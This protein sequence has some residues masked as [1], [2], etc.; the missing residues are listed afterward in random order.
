MKYLVRGFV[1]LSVFTLAFYFSGCENQSPISSL[2]QELDSKI[3]DLIVQSNVGPIQIVQVDPEYLSSKSLNKKIESDTI[4]YIEEFMEADDDGE[5]EIKGGQYG[6]SKLK[7]D[8]HSL[9]MDM[10]VYMEWPNNSTFEGAIGSI[11]Y[12][13]NVVLNKPAELELTIKRANL[14]GVSESNLALFMYD[15][16]TDQWDN[17][18]AEFDDHKIKVD[19]DRFGKLKVFEVV[20]GE[21]RELY[22]LDA[23]AHF[24]KKL[25]K[26]DKGGKVEVGDKNSG[27]SKLDFDKYSLPHDVTI[28]FEWAPANSVIGMLNNMEFGPHGLQFN[29]PVE[30]ELSY[31]M[32]DLTGVPED[33]LRIFYFN[34]TTSMWELIG[35]TVD[36]DKKLV[37]VLLNHFSRYAVAISR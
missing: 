16:N 17:L 6:K 24:A 2:K 35:G 11:E 5:L 30:C 33:S 32:A 8:K 14:A 26:E 9:F 10:T 13:T 34:D 20:N 23:N 27:K 12:G 18:N 28:A 4:F 36:K 37:R 31:E 1:A 3:S 25:I 21:L 29:V 22:R 15:E 7:I 19:I